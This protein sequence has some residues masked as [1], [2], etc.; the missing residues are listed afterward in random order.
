MAHALGHHVL[1]K[2]SS[3]DGKA[4]F[5]TSNQ[6]LREKEANRFT[7]ELLMPAEIIE[8]LIANLEPLSMESMA[9]RLSVS[10]VALKVR[11]EGLG[12]L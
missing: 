7:L 5:S 11:L 6:D 12:Y 8:Y 3:R 1:H 9:E 4:S 10:Q 2:K